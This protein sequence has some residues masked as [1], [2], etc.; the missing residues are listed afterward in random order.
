VNAGELA[1]AVCIS[2]RWQVVLVT[3]TLAPQL[4]QAWQVQLSVDNVL[5]EHYETAV[6]FNAPDRQFRIGVTFSN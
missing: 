3:G 2:A 6:G 4:A 5:D 1:G